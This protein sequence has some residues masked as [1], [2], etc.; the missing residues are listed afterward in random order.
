MK[1]DSNRKTFNINVYS[2]IN[3]R[4]QRYCNMDLENTVFHLG[5]GKLESKQTFKNHMRKKH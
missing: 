1:K 5:Q 3:K 2:K 4:E